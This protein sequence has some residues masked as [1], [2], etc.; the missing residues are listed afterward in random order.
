MRASYAGQTGSSSSTVATTL[1]AEGVALVRCTAA[2]AFAA[3]RVR[4]A[5]VRLPVVTRTSREFLGDGFGV[6]TLWLVLTELRAC[7]AV[8]RSATGR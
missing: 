4:D 6:A 5:F 2:A 1:A 8:L 3:R 7:V